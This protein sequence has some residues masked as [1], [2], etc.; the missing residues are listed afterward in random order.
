MYEADFWIP[1]LP[2]L[3]ADQMM[4]AVRSRYRKR[5]RKLIGELVVY[6]RQKPDA[7][8]VEATLICTRYSKKAPDYG[9]LVYS[10]KPLVDGLVEHGVLKDDS[11]DVLKIEIYHWEK[12]GEGEGVEIKVRQLR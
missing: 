5:W 7:P 3:Q 1:E 11:M 8:L 2:T 4:L 10:F 6:E 12:R 9:N